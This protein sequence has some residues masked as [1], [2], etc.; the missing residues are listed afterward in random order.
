MF[1]KDLDPLHTSPHNFNLSVNHYPVILGDIS[2]NLT[3]NSRAD[4]LRMFFL[5]CTGYK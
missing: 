5:V 1:C 3:P 4:L 2:S